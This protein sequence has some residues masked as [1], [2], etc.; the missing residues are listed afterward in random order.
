M[1]AKEWERAAA[2]LQARLPGFRPIRFGFVSEGDWI[3]R[4]IFADSSRWSAAR[5]RIHL[6]PLPLFVPAPGLSMGRGF[7]L[8]E[9]KLWEIVD[10]ELFGAIERALP[11]LDRL[12][13][14]ESLVEQEDKWE[15]N[16]Y[17]AE[18]RLCVGVI[19]R[20]HAMVDDVR[21]VLQ[22]PAESEDEFIDGAR[23]RCAS[24]VETI[25][26]DGFDVA[27][28]LLAARR[29]DVLALLD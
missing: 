8:D 19:W 10:E 23:E 24:L 26:S 29:S 13:T 21:R 15:I 16:I 28:R 4:C 9:G 27:E 3:A 18:L 1:K 6:F 22:A 5:I 20:D 14:L 25:D 7:R 17:Q 11:E 2:P 12:A